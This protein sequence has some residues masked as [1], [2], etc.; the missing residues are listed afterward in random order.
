MSALE[1]IAEPFVFHSSAI[2]QQQRTSF[3]GS[4]VTATLSLLIFPQEGSCVT[5]PKQKPSSFDCVVARSLNL[6][7]KFI[8]GMPSSTFASVVVVM[9]LASSFRSTSAL[10]TRSMATRTTSR[11]FATTQ[12]E[13]KTDND[14]PKVKELP[15][16]YSMDEIVSLCKRRGIIFPSSEIYNGYAGFY[17]YGPLGSELKKNV[18]DAWWKAFVTQREDVVGLDSSIIHN[19]AT[20]KSSGRSTVCRRFLLSCV[21]IQVLAQSKKNFLDFHRTCRRIFGPNGGL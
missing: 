17:D 18:K 11:L 14:Q 10:I 2:I 3:H 6:C 9:W 5:S 4:N 15:V 16:K 20:W 7:I 12:A 8:A 13:A 21:T 19:P 1:T